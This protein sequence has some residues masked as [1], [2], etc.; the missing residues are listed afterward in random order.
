MISYI[1]LYIY[2]S[3]ILNMCIW[4][5]RH[6]ER[7]REKRVALETCIWTSQETCVR[8]SKFDKILNII[9]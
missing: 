9:N 1:T 2:V 5:T 6:T 7:A 4:D 3:N 8:I